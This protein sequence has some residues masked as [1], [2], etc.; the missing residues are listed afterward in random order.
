[1]IKKDD[2]IIKYMSNIDDTYLNDN[3]N[4][5]DENY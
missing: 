5:V 4:D 3:L 2:T 1:M